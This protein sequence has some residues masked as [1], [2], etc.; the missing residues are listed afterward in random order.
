MELLEREQH[1]TELNAALEESSRGMGRLVLVSGEAGIGKTVLVEAFTRSHQDKLSTLWG[2]CDLLFTPRPLGPLHDIAA[3]MKGNLLGRL[4]SGTN[5]STIFSTFM[6]ELQRTATMVVIE[7]AHW[8]DEATLDLIKFLGRRIQRTLTLLIITYR[9]DELGSRHPLRIVLGDLA[10]SP[11]VRRISLEPLTETAVRGLVGAR[12]MDASA[13]YHQTG[14]NPFFVT[15]ALSNAGGLIPA[16]IRDAVLARTSRLTLSA[17]AVLQAAAVIG[18]RVEAR[19]LAE[20]TGAELS[21]VEECLGIGILVS[22]AG[23]LVFRHELARQTILET[24]SPQ[25]SQVLHQLTLDALKSSPA[26]RQD[27]ARLAHHAEAAGDLD[28]VLEFAPA[29]ARHAANAGAHR[30]AAALYGLTLRTAGNAATIERGIWFEEYADE[31]HTLGALEESTVIRRQAIQ[32]FRAVNNRQREG[33]NLALLAVTLIN[34]GQPAAARQASQE[35]LD[36]LLGLPPGPELA[37]AQRTQA[38]LLML[39]RDCA[40]AVIWGNQ[41]IALAERF[42]DRETLARAYTTVGAALLTTDYERGRSS[43]EKSSTVCQEIGWEFGV[44]NVYANLGSISCEVFRLHEAEAYLHE[45]LDYTSE[46]DLDF[47]GKYMLAW[48]ALTL[49]YLGHWEK[50]MQ[51]SSESLQ[52]VGQT[53]ISRIPGLVALGRLQARQGKANAFSYLDEALDLAL[54]SQTFQRV[55][56]VRAARAEAAWLAGDVERALKEAC[57]IYDLAVSKKHPWFAGELAFWRWRAGGDVPVSEWLASPYALHIAGDWHGAAEAWERLSCPYEQARALADGDVLAQIAALHIFEQL[58]ALTDADLLRNRLKAA[59]AAGV[60]RR[61]RSSTRENPFG[62]TNRQYDILN[63]LI[64]HLS[65][66]EIAAR[67]YISPKTV[68]HHVS[69]ILSKLGVHSREQAADLAQKHPHYK[70]K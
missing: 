51:S 31:Q 65:N 68:D 62:I 66:A 27:L 30:E 69:A 13:L 54:Q 53:A 55:S 32:T 44:A 18:Q 19:L 40:E 50:A 15:E 61:L 26:A 35:A 56:L 63:L 57:A 39:N 45:G 12:A 10:S 20:V 58:G 22:Q 17:Q 11:A 23:T 16:T 25:R 59:G 36:L 6:G 4:N 8:A 52:G 41:A 28:A 37:L 33:L 9:D 21:A 60:P 24:I 49:L 70:K 38:H 47:L 46:R 64:I 34:T 67:L 43:L 14:G 5:R 48:Q 1:L 7:D 29:A 3:Q 42:N 2:A